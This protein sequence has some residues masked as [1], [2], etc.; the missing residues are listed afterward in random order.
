VTFASDRVASS[1]GGIGSR[2]LGHDR[3][4]HLGASTA[5]S[6]ASFAT[7]ASGDFEHA[8]CAFDLAAFLVAADM[9][10]T[11]VRV[12]PAGR[13]SAHEETARG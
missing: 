12:R 9:S 13:F 2:G 1:A 11:S 6:L 5:L 7:Q 10:E 8:E 4:P 3:D